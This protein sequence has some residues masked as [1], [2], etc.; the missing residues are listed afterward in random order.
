MLEITV[1]LSLRLVSLELYLGEI[2]GIKTISSLL[3]FVTILCSLFSF[4][5]WDNYWKQFLYA[6]LLILLLCLLSSVKTYSGCACLH[7]KSWR[8]MC[9]KCCYRKVM[10][11]RIHLTIFGVNFVFI[12]IDAAIGKMLILKSSSYHR[13]IG[14]L[15][16]EGIHK[17]YIHNLLK[18]C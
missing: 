3:I 6:I 11:L 8:K 12:L 5:L 16:L 15:E 9:S 10:I 18:Y 17:E 7:R 4:K 1:N 14:Y 13:L 2:K